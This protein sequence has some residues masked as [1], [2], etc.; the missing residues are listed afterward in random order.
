MLLQPIMYIFQA[1][2][3]VIT[4]NFD[5]LSKTQV[6]LGGIVSS[7][8][9]AYA[10]YKGIA[11]TQGVIN[12]LKGKDLLLEGRAK[13]AKAATFAMDKANAVVDIIKGAWSSLGVIPFVGAALAATAIAGGIAYLYSQSS[14]GDDIMSPG[15]GGSG[16]GSR[17]LFGPEGAIQLNNKDTVLAGTDLFGKADDMMSAPKGALQVSNKTAST[18]TQDTNALLIAEMKRGNDQRAEQLRLQ[19]KDTFVSTLRIQ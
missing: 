18:P 13:A 17:T 8:T 4:G 2:A 10:V 1:I 5:G 19:K 11:A 7:L 15:T 9:G 3:G 6:V 12:A 14:K 16:Y